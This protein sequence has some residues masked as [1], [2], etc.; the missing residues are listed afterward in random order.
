MPLASKSG[1][2]YG[3]LLTPAIPEV[4]MCKAGAD[5]APTGFALLRELGIVRRKCGWLDVAYKAV[6]VSEGLV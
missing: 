2:L 4:E 3:G 5:L 6:R 1:G